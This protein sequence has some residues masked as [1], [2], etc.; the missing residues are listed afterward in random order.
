MSRNDGEA[1]KFKPKQGYRFQKG[2]SGNPAGRPKGT[3]KAQAA[4]KLLDSIGTDSANDI[5]ESVIKAAKAGDMRAAEIVLAGLWPLRRGR[6]IVMDL[7]DTRTLEGLQAAMAKVVEIMSAGQI[8]SEEAASI[9]AVLE[10]NRK[11]IETVELQH[12]LQTLEDKVS[13]SNVY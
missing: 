8:S 6:P 3:G 13:Q 1:D 4:T 9:T 5:L 11:I 12:R 2:Q 10:T 7:P